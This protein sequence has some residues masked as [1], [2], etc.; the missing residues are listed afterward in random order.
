[1]DKSEKIKIQAFVTVSALV[2][3]GVAFGSS[4]FA[5]VTPSP[6]A[7]ISS[8]PADTNSDPQAS[9]ENDA[10]GILN[11][12]SITVGVSTE[13]PDEND[14]VE[15]VEVDSDVQAL[16]AENQMEYYAFNQDITDAEQS[17]NQ[18]DA[19]D[20]RVAAAIVTSLTVPEV[21]AMNTDNI[22]AHTIMT[23][24]QK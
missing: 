22:E 16:D 9:D 10:E 19:A 20:L 1:M 3:Y 7:T 24:A 21:T 5:D 13:L 18:G 23:G 14:S 4:A 8:A 6:I 17:G 11:G 2:L 12:G 15:P